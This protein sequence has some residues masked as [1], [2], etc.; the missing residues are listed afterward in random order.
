[1]TNSPHSLLEAA[2]C[3]NTS[4]VR[5]LVKDF[6]P[7]DTFEPLL[8]SAQNGHIECVKLLAD[9]SKYLNNDA[10]CLAA[11]NGHTQCVEYLIP[12]SMPHDMQNKALREACYKGHLECV[13]L[14]IPVSDFSENN[15]P[16]GALGAAVVGGHHDCMEAVY[17]LCDAERELNNMKKQYTE[18]M[19]GMLEQYHHHR[20]SQQQKE[21][22]LDSVSTSLVQR[23]RKI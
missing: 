10:L 23:L 11:K 14:L 18:D 2:R 7:N 3:G 5:R 12:I 21:V 1:M 8:Q 9:S 19:W 13:Q 6:S 17:D 16:A 22:L 4:E 20:V 15:D